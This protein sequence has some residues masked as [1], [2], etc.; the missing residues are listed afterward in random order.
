MKKIK[1][2][3]IRLILSCWLGIILLPAARIAGQLPNGSLADTAY[4]NFLTDNLEAESLLEPDTANPMQLANLSIDVIIVSD[5]EGNPLADPGSLTF[6]LPDINRY[7][8]KIGIRFHWGDIRV[9]PEYDYGTIND[10]ADTRE[11]EVK[12]ARQ[13]T[14]NMFIVDS[15]RLDSIDYFGYAV[16]PDDTSRNQLF[17]AA[18][19]ITANTV[20]ALLGNFFGLL[21][22]HETAGGAELENGNN[23]NSSG[24]FLCDT[25]GDGGMYQQVNEEC[26]YQGY[27]T[28]PSGR[29]YT[30]SVANVMSDSPDACRC[31]FT[32]QQY[33]R[34]LYYYL[35]H[36][37][38]LR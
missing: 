15:I 17:I 6:L 29:Y 31:L 33:G 25:Y 10:R 11:M 38:Y 36:R 3:K 26:L 35:N 13:R 30:P 32:L 4:I 18:D 21:R 24:D 14:I 23:C 8:S 7:F 28:D 12:Y 16:F 2:L 9:I 5:R 19:Q 37:H 27:A 20:S 22:T 1:P 34:M